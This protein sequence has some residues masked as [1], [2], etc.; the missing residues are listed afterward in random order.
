MKKSRALYTLVLLLFVF[1]TLI[2]TSAAWFATFI[3][4]ET[5]GEFEGSAMISYFAGGEGTKEKPYIILNDHHLY[6][7]AWL[8]NSGSFGDKVYYF[9]ISD[10]NGNPI[11]AL[12][13]AGGISGD[14]DESGA[15]PPIGTS[16]HPFKGYF[17]GMGATI[18]NV[19]VSTVKDDW[20]EQPD[21]VSEYTDKYVG[22]FGYVGQGAIIEDFVLDKIEV[23]SHI[24]DATVGIVCGYVGGMVYNVGVYNGI[25]DLTAGSTAQSKYT[26]IGEKS[27]D[28]TW[29]DMPTIDSE[30]GEGGGESGGD[31]DDDNPTQDGGQGWGGSMSMMDLTKR[32]I[33]ISSLS[34]GSKNTS[35]LYPINN[36]DYNLNAW[37]G[38]QAPNTVDRNTNYLM[39]GTVLPLNVD[40]TV[41]FATPINN[42][43]NSN[44]VSGLLTTEYYTTHSSE[45]VDSKNTGYIAVGTGTSTRDS[46]IR[47]RMYQFDGL[48]KS[49]NK[50]SGTNT[51]A[52][53]Y[54][55]V[56]DK[57]VLLGLDANGNFVQLSDTYNNIISGNKSNS[58]FTSYSKVDADAT[59]QN[60][61]KVRTALDTIFTGNTYNNTTTI[62]G[63]RFYTAINGTTVSAPAGAQMCGTPIN[64][65]VSN[66]INFRVNS[67]GLITAVA[68]SFFQSSNHSLFDIYEV[69][70]SGGN[71]SAVYKISKI[72]ADDSGNIYYVYDGGSDSYDGNTAYTKKYDVAWTDSKIPSYT[73]SYYEIPVKTGEYAIGGENGAY[74]MYLDIGANGS[75]G[76]SSSGGGGSGG[77]GSGGAIKIDVNDGV[78]TTKFV[79]TNGKLGSDY[80]QVP[81]A[82][83]DRAFI[84]GSDVSY[85]SPG[86]KSTYYI[87]TANINS[88]TSGGKTFGT[89]CNVGSSLG[90]V[91]ANNFEQ[92]DT[93]TYVEG[94]ATLAS[95]GIE[96]NEHFATRMAEGGGTVLKTNATAPKQDALT[97][98]TLS[99]GEKVYLPTNSVWFKPKK[100][101]KC[102]IAFSVGKMNDNKHRSIYRIHRD[103]DGNIDEWQETTLTFLKA[104]NFKNSEVVVFQYEIDAQDAA[105][106]YEFAVGAST[107]ENDDSVYFYFLA[108]AGASE[109]DGDDEG[110]GEGSG[111]DGEIVDG[112]YSSVMFDIDYVVSPDTDVSA[113]D[114]VNHQ[115]L[116]KFEKV[117]T[118]NDTKLYFLAAGTQ[119]TP[120]VGYY[121]PTGVTVTDISVQNQSTAIN[122][123]TAQ[124]PGGVYFDD[125]KTKPS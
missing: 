43:T 83:E 33:Y 87:Y 4:A 88:R 37:M 100:P 66:S 60:Y 95:Y 29:V 55:N 112:V 85:S 18:S 117:Q 123:P 104:P 99:T 122:S 105:E 6:N 96:V 114:Y 46:A 34:I 97:E 54:E 125:R 3:T 57:L 38:A 41:M 32:L 61:T 36:T 39:A 86:I 82:L 64:D 23:K 108:L 52:T 31:N 59:Y 56:S 67:S 106:H 119:E 16:T 20:K 75:G 1:S 27:D 44:G 81:G 110:G 111:G 65:L 118:A 48:Y 92:I 62:Q 113:E 8:Q 76:G 116:L 53:L 73:L 115:T 24:T 9:Q 12:E 72:Y 101:G 78:L 19:W 89:G 63:L 26:L 103:E 45:L 90:S 5:D 30:Y 50:T 77:D 107:G 124:L 80:I 47:V 69:E 121:A 11:D 28:I 68:G 120:T 79:G 42:Y 71:V 58:F 91:G 40:T 70:R 109:T 49:F 98:V 10:K 7:L 35:S 84:V 74:L 14:D 51:A 21:G 93:D 22:L 94:N 15:I 2:T 13:M 17:N 25:V 102:V